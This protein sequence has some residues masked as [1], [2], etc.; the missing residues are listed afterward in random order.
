MERVGDI[1][2]LGGVRNV[3]LN[4]GNENG[5]RAMEVRTGSGFRFT[6]L[7]DRGMDISEAEYAGRSLCWRSYTG[8]V[9]P[10]FFE[11]E[12]AG[13]LRGFFGGLLT[14]CG[15]TY[16]G[17]AG[18]DEGEALGLHGRISYTPARNVSAG[19]EWQNDE[20]LISV[21]GRV[22][23]ASALAQRVTLTRN[24]S[25]KLGASSLSIKDTVENEGHTSCPFM[26]LYHVNFG[27]PVVGGD[28]VLIAPSK[29]VVTIAREKVTQPDLYRRFQ[30][31][32]PGFKEMV[33]RH[34]TVP[35]EEGYVTVA[36]IN[37]GLECC[38]SYVRYRKRELP[39]LF[40]WKMLAQGAYVVGLEPATCW[41]EPRSRARER[42]QLN[43]LE[44]GQAV[45]QHVE[46]GVCT[47][48]AEIQK[49]EESILSMRA[50]L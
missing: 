5:V 44:P 50:E 12:G 37:K 42:G 10:A 3:T 40:Q 36:L 28:T 17:Q 27:F 20:Y 46:I 9:A 47:S 19:G 13:W 22:S 35:D 16:I 34:E 6:V 1:S 4:D 33:F 7:P 15:L 18:T 39:H 21:R 8:D 14:T 2:Q 45:H 25:T 43:F 31:P 32:T 38:G 48:S 26:M 11:P 29:D 23:E 24:I 49:L 30:N 41:A